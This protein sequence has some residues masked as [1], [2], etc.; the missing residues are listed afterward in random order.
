MR[1]RGGSSPPPRTTYQTIRTPTKKVA[2]KFSP[3][4]NIKSISFAGSHAG[5]RC[6]AK[7][8][9]APRSTWPTTYEE[10]QIF[11]I[12]IFRVYPIHQHAFS[13]AAVPF[14]FFT[15]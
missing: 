5:I 7:S 1:K 10:K 13:A 11:F 9:S 14:S 3:T 6:S 15:R 4:E 12:K 2:E 8:R